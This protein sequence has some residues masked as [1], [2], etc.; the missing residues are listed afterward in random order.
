ME[1]ETTGDLFEIRR[2]VKY[3]ERGKRN[4]SDLSLSEL[5]TY[6]RNTDMGRVQRDANQHVENLR[7][8][9]LRL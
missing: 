5:D 4:N 2:R 7:L 1:L 6:T 9:R 3:D 8:A